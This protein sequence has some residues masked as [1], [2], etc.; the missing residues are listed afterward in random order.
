METNH[1]PNE[2]T[3]GNKIE[4]TSNNPLSRLVGQSA[5]CRE[6]VRRIV[7]C[8]RHTEPV[9]LVGETGTGK[10]LVAE[11]IHLLGSRASKIFLRV[12]CGGL[13]GELAGNELFG[14]ERGAY[15]GAGPQ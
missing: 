15:T 9:L 6:I 10:T 2:G 3:Q 14:H 8:A 13:S 1:T 11:I 5:L 7:N 12:N 4:K